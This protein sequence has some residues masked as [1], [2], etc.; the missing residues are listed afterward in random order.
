MPETVHLELMDKGAFA[1]FGL[2]FGA[3]FCHRSDPLSTPLPLLSKA[4]N[5][6]AHNAISASPIKST[7][8]FPAAAETATFVTHRDAGFGWRGVRCS[9]CWPCL[10]ANRSEYHHHDHDHDHHDHHNLGAAGGWCF[11]N[12]VNYSLFNYDCANDCFVLNFHLHQFH[13]CTNHCQAID[14][15]FNN[16]D[17]DDVGAESNRDP[18]REGP[19]GWLPGSRRAGAGEAADRTED[20]YGQN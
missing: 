8:D 17:L 3:S 13:S 2:S 16:N 14:D 4:D 19:E 5:N 7:E 1:P 18:T 11:D 9:A 12:N 15:H 10:C 20:R 6:N